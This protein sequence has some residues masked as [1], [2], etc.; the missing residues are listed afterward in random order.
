[1]SNIFD[2]SIHPFGP[3]C[4]FAPHNMTSEIWMVDVERAYIWI[5]FY[6]GFISLPVVISLGGS[7]GTHVEVVTKP[8]NAEESLEDAPLF[9]IDES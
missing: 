4:P 3:H 9:L 6:E 2:F 8:L 7:G 1:M 5:S